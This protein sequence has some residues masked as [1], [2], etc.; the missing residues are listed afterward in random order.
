MSPPTLSSS[1][2]PRTC[3]YSGDPTAAYS[4]GT[5]GITSCATRSR[6]DS[7]ARV[8]STHAESCELSGVADPGEA[9]PRRRV[10]GA[11]ETF[12]LAG[13]IAGVHAAS[14]RVIK[15]ARRLFMD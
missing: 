14:R 15:N 5:H 1:T 7:D 2:H 10:A 4:P 13:C 6:A 12:G 8:A 9:F 11:P 3:S